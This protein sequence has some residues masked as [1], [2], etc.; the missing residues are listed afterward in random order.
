MNKKKSRINPK[1][2][3]YMGTPENLVQRSIHIVYSRCKGGLA[4]GKAKCRIWIR[5]HSTNTRHDQ[6]YEKQKIRMVR[7]AGD[8]WLVNTSSWKGRPSAIA[9]VERTV[10]SLYLF[11]SFHLRLNL[12]D[13]V[14]CFG[15]YF[16][17]H[18][19]AMYTTQPGRNIH[20][21]AFITFRGNH[22]FIFNLFYHPFQ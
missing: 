22:L 17:V 6:R 8:M 1:H 12:L 21:T 3:P 2:L 11:Y 14:I 10:P 19:L 20:V 5:V 7:A 4:V 16:F 15:V 9:M 13:E 18:R